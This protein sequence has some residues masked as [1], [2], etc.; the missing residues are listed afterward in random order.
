VIEL[1]NQGVYQLLPWS[2]YSDN[3][4]KMDNTYPG[5]MATGAPELIFEDPQPLINTNRN[6]CNLFSLLSIGYVAQFSSPTQNV[7]D[8][9]E[10]NDGRV[11]PSYVPSQAGYNASFDPTFT[12]GRDPRMEYNILTDR[13]LVIQNPIHAGRVDVTAQ[14]YTVPLGADRNGSGQ[15]AGYS[16]TGYGIKKFTPLRLNRFDDA[17]TSTVMAKYHFIQPQLRLAEVYLFFAEAAN[18]AY[19]PTGV[20]PGTT[21]S[22]EQA[23]NIVRT[24]AGM[25]NV[26][27][28]FTASTE[29]FRERVWNER[30]VELC[31]EGHRWYDVRRWYIA[32]LDKYKSQWGLSFDKAHTFF[33]P[34]NVKPIVFNLRDYWLPLPTDQVTIYK[35][36]Y[37]NPGW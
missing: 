32:H 10:L 9:F 18:E 17:N 28:E 34:Y 16:Q 37:Q 14:L 33:T 21:L 27:S 31:F 25:V 15:A 4:Y 7:V 20:V 35:E 1:A 11:I 3:F 26:R 36:L 6:R 13:A 19:G 12:S 29:L 2:N 30:S 24:R 22:A 5:Q 8:K 23:V